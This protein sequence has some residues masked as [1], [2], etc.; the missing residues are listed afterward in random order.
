MTDDL[1]D[2]A[3]PPGPRLSGRRRYGAAMSL[4]QQGRLTPDQL[5][6]YR[7]CA[8][9]D[10]Q[11]PEPLL[12]GGA[13]LPAPAPASEPKALLRDL[14]DEIDLYLAPLPGP[15]VAEIR[16]QINRSR[17]RAVALHPRQNPVVQACLPAA[18][19]ALT[20][21]HPDLAAAIARAAPHLNWITYDGYDP[22]RIG[23]AFALG[24]AYTSLIGE[25]AAIAAEGFDL[26]LFVIAPQV[27]Y[28]DHH[29]AAPE[30]YV[31]LTGPHGWRF[32][33]DTPLVIKPA[34]APVWN[35]PFRPHATKVGP[36]PFLA[37]FGW[38]DAV[39]ALAQVI[40]ARDWPALEAL[41]LV[42]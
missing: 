19:A 14:L 39:Q 30:L 29:H 28:R 15:G 1:S 20:K 23:A 37:L 40:P 26:G 36:T 42:P 9:L 5:E 3:T 31:P 17:H 4:Y 10:G 25:D 32:G 22:A 7:I 41:R 21:T 27:F 34:H 38:T 35:D 33:P 8:L 24:H 12:P 13:P 18:L 11:D 16:S 6:V 2:I